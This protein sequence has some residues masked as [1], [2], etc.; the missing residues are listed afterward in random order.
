MQT[1]PPVISAPVAQAFL[2][3]PYAQMSRFQLAGVLDP[4]ADAQV[5]SSMLPFY[6]VAWDQQED[7]SGIAECLFSVGG[8]PG[9]GDYLPPVAVNTSHVNYSIAELGLRSGGIY[10]STVRCFNRAGLSSLNFS[11][12]VAVDALGPFI[13][14]VMDGSYSETTIDV[15]FV[16]DDLH[17]YA[18]WPYAVDVHTGLKECWAALGTG[19]STDAQRASIMGWR[20]TGTDLFIDL[21]QP[22]DQLLPTNVKLFWSVGC[23]D[24]VGNWANAS[25][26]GF[27]VDRTPPIVRPGFLAVLDGSWD[28]LL[29]NG[30]TDF[31]VPDVSYWT[32]R[33]EYLCRAPHVVDYE[34]GVPNMRFFLS[35]RANL[36][37]PFIAGP[38]ATGGGRLA[39]FTGL[40]LTQNTSVYCVVVAENGNGQTSSF[41][42]DGAFVDYTAPSC[43]VKAVS[44]ALDLPM[45]YT[46]TL[47]LRSLGFTGSWSAVPPLSV[48]ALTDGLGVM[49]RC[50]DAESGWGALSLTLGYA[51]GEAQLR[52][53]FDVVA[54]TLRGADG[55]APT[56][57]F[58]LD[59][60][61]L[62]ATGYE[63][64]R[65]LYWTARAR[66]RAGV[67]SVFST[68]AVVLDGTA[69][70][71]APWWATPAAVI[72]GPDF[73]GR[74]IT[75]SANLTHVNVSTYFVDQESDIGVV[76]VGLS[77]VPG[78]LVPGDLPWNGS[79]TSV[80]APISLL[81][82]ANVSWVNA[83]T[84]GE[85]ATVTI[86]LPQA[87]VRA[88]NASDVWTVW[89]T[90]R[91]VNTVGQESRF[92]SAG[93]LLDATPPVC[94]PM[95]ALGAPL[96]L[97]GLGDAATSVLDPR[98]GDATHQSFGGVL[99]ARYNCSDDGSGMDRYELSAELWT[100]S[101]WLPVC[102]PAGVGLET[103]GATSRC[104]VE[105][106]GRYRVRVDAYNRVGLRTVLLT[107][108]V[109]VDTT[110][111]SVGLL[112]LHPVPNGGT[113]RVHT[114]AAFVVFNL[115]F[116]SEP[117]SAL[118]SVHVAVGRMGEASVL[119]WVD[120]T[121]NV[122]R[123]HT[124][125]NTS[126]I[127]PNLGLQL[128][129]R[130]EVMVQVRNVLGL[131]RLATTATFIVDWTPATVGT[132]SLSTVALPPSYWRL[133]SFGEAEAGW[134]PG[135][136]VT[137]DLRGWRDEESGLS[138]FTVNLFSVPPARWASLGLQAITNPDAVSAFASQGRSVQAN[139]LTDADPLRVAAT[140]T[141]APGMTSVTFQGVTLVQ[142]MILVPWVTIRNGIN[143][144]TSVGG[145]NSTISMGVL[146]PG[147]VFDGFT[148]LADAAALPV[149]NGVWT[150]WQPFQDSSGARVSYTVG[151]GTARGSADLTGWVRA[152]GADNFASV[153]DRVV[154]RDGTT[155]FATVWGNSSTGMS[156]NSS[157]DGVLYDSSAPSLSFA[158]LGPRVG[159]HAVW[160][161]S[162][163]P[164]SVNWLC[165]DP[166]SNVSAVEV[167]LGSGPFAPASLVP[168]T[169]VPGTALAAGVFEFPLVALTNFSTLV[170]Q[171]TCTNSAGL[172]S[173]HLT[174][175]S[176]TDVT[177]PRARNVSSTA[178]VLSSVWPTRASAI[179][180]P[181]QFVSLP[182]RLFV[183]WDILDAES[184][185]G[186]A[187][188]CVGSS[189]NASDVV[190]CTPVGTTKG[191]VLLL[192]ASAAEGYNCSAALEGPAREGGLRNF[193]CL[194]LPAVAPLRH[195]M[196]LY[197][198][199]SVAN[200]V[201]LTT[202]V[203]ARAVVDAVAPRINATAA[204]LGYAW[205]SAASGMAASSLLADD[206]VAFLARPTMLEVVMGPPLPTS[207]A[208]LDAYTFTVLHAANRSVF[209][210]PVT[211]PVKALEPVASA[212]LPGASLAVLTTPAGAVFA[213]GSAY[214]VRIS[215]TTVGGL[216]SA[217]A[218]ALAYT[219]DAVPPV[220]AAA[221]I[222]TSPAVLDAANASAAMSAWPRT[223]SLT[224]F[225]A[226]SDD[227][228]IAASEV[229]VCD[230]D[231][232][233]GACVT[234]WLRVNG[235]NSRGSGN[236]TANAT[237]GGV[238]LLPGRRFFVRVRLTDA[239]GQ[240]AGRATESVIVENRAP[241]PGRM[242]A[243]AGFV[244]HPADL[245]VA[246]TP[247]SSPTT[248]VDRYDVCIVRSTDKELR[249]PLLPC[250]RVPP[251]AI[252]RTTRTLRGEELPTLDIDL[253]AA[254]PASNAS[255]LAALLSTNRNVTIVVRGT[256]GAGLSSL[257]YS[258]PVIYDPTGPGIA[259]TYAADPVAYALEFATMTG[260]NVTLQPG[261]VSW[262]RP[263][264]PL[265]DSRAVKNAT[266]AKLAQLGS[267][268]LTGIGIAWAG[269]V[270]PESGI[271]PTALLTVMRCVNGTWNCSVVADEEA[272]RFATGFYL[273]Q[274][275]AV[276]PN[277]TFRANLTVT[278]GAGETAS[279]VTSIPLTIDLEPPLVSRVSD[280][281][282]LGVELPRGFPGRAAS[283]LTD[284]V[285]YWASETTAAGSWEATDASGIANYMWAVCRAD[286]TAP[287][288]VASDAGCPVPWS[289]ADA[290]TW[291]A[292]PLGATRLAPGG[293][294]RTWVRATDTAGN[295]AV[296]SSSGYVVDVTGPVVD[297]FR[298]DLP[299][300]VGS[301]RILKPAVWGVV[302]AE[303]GIAEVQICLTI[304]AA[305]NRT[306]RVLLPCTA[307]PLVQSA[308]LPFERY[309][310][311]TTAAE[312]DAA[313]QEELDARA[314]AG[315]M[316]TL[317]S[318]DIVVRNRAALASRVTIGAV[319]VD[320]A[321]VT[322]RWLFTVE[323][324]S[325]ERVGFNAS[326]IAP[327][328]SA[329]RDLPNA[330]SNTTELG[331]AW[332]LQAPPSGVTSLSVGLGTECGVANVVLPAALPPGAT[333][334]SFRAQDL[335]PRVRY[336]LTLNTTTGA[337]VLSTLCSTPLLVD[338]DPP[339]AGVVVDGFPNAT[340]DVGTAANSTFAASTLVHAHGVF[341]A[342]WSGFSD[343]DTRVVS[344]AA[345]VCEASGVACLN[346]W[347]TVS[348][349]TQVAFANLA[350]EDGITYRVH[351]RG[352]DSAG[353]ACEARS[354]GQ[355]YD[356]SVPVPPRR[357]VLPKPVVS[358]WGELALD[359]EEFVDAESGIDRYE[360]ELAVRNR[361][362]TFHS[363]LTPTPIG[364]NTAYMLSGA[365]LDAVDL[366]W[367]GA[368]LDDG[369]RPVRYRAT[370][371]AVNRAG[372]RSHRQVFGK[373]DDTPP[374]GGE[375]VFQSVDG[376]PGA[377]RLI[378]SVANASTGRVEALIADVDLGDP[379]RYQVS[380]HRLAIAFRGF[381]D[382]E[383][384]TFRASDQIVYTYAVG[385][386]PGGDEIV[387]RARFFVP[388]YHV[389]D[390]ASL[391]GVERLP[392]TDAHMVHTIRLTGLD[393]PNGA[394]VYA[395][396]AA[397]NAAGAATQVV[398]APMTIDATTPQS[399]HLQPLIDLQARVTETWNA[400]AFQPFNASAAPGS[401]N[402]S[403]EHDSFGGYNGVGSDAYA[404][405]SADISRWTDADWSGASGALSFAWRGWH[406]PQSALDHVEYSVVELGEPAGYG[407]E[408]RATS[409]ASLLSG[410]ARVLNLAGSYAAYLAAHSGNTARRL[411][412]S[413]V[414]ARQLLQ[415]QQTASTDSVAAVPVDAAAYGLTPFNR[416]IEGPLDGN[417]DIAD[418]RTVPGAEL[419]AALAD[420]RAD[421]PLQ[422]AFR[423][424]LASPFEFW[425]GKPVTP[426]VNAGA[427]G[428]GN[429]TVTA[430]L[431]AGKV[432]GIALRA[433]SASS[434][435]TQV[436]SDGIRVDT[437][438]GAPCFG[439]IK[440][441]IASARDDDP[442]HLAV[443]SSAV[444]HAPRPSWNVTVDPNDPLGTRPVSDPSAERAY[445][446]YTD[447]VLL[448][449]LQYGD[450][451]VQR[452]T[453]LQRLYVCPEVDGYAPSDLNSL[454]VG[455]GDEPDP[456]PTQERCQLSLAPLLR[457]SLRL[458][459]LADGPAEGNSTAS[460]SSANTVPAARVP[461]NA[462]AGVPL[463]VASPDLLPGSDACCRGGQDRHEPAST[464][465]DIEL[466][467]VRPV[468]GF[469][470]TLA[471]VA[472]PGRGSSDANA[473][474]Y[475]VVGSDEGT[476]SVVALHHRTGAFRLLDF[477][478]AT[479]S[480][481][482]P[483]TVAASRV[484]SGPLPVPSALGVVTDTRVPSFAVSNDEELGVYEVH[485]DTA[486]A[487]R[488][489]AICTPPECAQD[490]GYAFEDMQ[491]LTRSEQ[492]YTVATLERDPSVFA[493]G[494]MG[495][496][497][498]LHNRTLAVG[499]AAADALRAA[500]GADAP[501]QRLAGAVQVC[502]DAVN[503]LARFARRTAPPSGAAA[504]LWLAPVCAVLTPPTAPLHGGSGV[505]EQV[506]P[507]LSRVDQ[508][509]FGTSLALGDG[510]LAV[511]APAS[512]PHYTSSDG[513]VLMDAV[514][515]HSVSRGAGTG[516][517]VPLAEGDAFSLQTSALLG[518]LLRNGTATNRNGTSAAPHRPYVLLDP[519]VIDAAAVPRALTFAHSG[520]GS[521][522]DV[523]PDGAALVVGAPA[524]ADGRGRVYAYTLDAISGE[525]RLACYFDGGLAGFSR[526]GESVQALPV[527]AP[528]AAGAAAAA[529]D[530]T[531][532]LAVASLHGLSLAAN[533]SAGEVAASV[534]VAVRPRAAAASA[535]YQ[536]LL[537]SSPRSSRVLEEM[538]VPL[539]P[540]VAVIGAN[541][542]LD[543]RVQLGLAPYDAAAEAAAAAAATMD[544]GAATGP[545]HT[546][547][548]DVVAAYLASVTDGGKRVA[549]A[550]VAPVV[551]AAGSHLL[552]ADALSPTWD[553][554]RFQPDELSLA[555]AVRNASLDEVLSP[556]DGQTSPPEAGALGTGR[557][558]HTAFCPRDAVRR[559]SEPQAAV[560][561]YV[562]RAC[563][564]QAGEAS[565][566]SYGGLSSICASCP[567]SG[568][569]VCTAGLDASG[570]PTSTVF[571]LN[572]TGLSLSQGAM[573]K[574][575]VRATTASG[576][577]FERA[578]PLLQVDATPPTPPSSGLLDGYYSSDAG[579]D[580]CNQDL[581]YRASLTTA[582]VW[583]AGFGEDASG[584]DRYKYGLSRVPCDG[585]LRRDCSTRTV[586]VSALDGVIKNFTDCSPLEV[587][588]RKAWAVR[589]GL[590]DWELVG[591]AAH[592]LPFDV[593]APGAF[594]VVPLYDAGLNT[595]HRWTRVVIPHA[596]LAF[597]CAI[598]YNRAGLRTIIA[599]NGLVY[600]ATPGNLTRGSV[601]DGLTGV[602][603]DQQATND[604]LTAAWVSYD[605]ES[606]IQYSVLAYTHDPSPVLDAY[607][608]IDAGAGARVSWDAVQVAVN[609][610]GVHWVMVPAGTQQPDMGKAAGLALERGR[611]YYA[612][613]RSLNGAGLWSAVEVSDGVTV[614]RNEIKP[615]P[616]KPATVGFDAISA[617]ANYASPEAQRT[618][619]QGTV[620]SLTLPAGALGGAAA[621]LL[622]GAVA[623]DDLAGPN[624]TA[625]DLPGL[626]DPASTAPPKRNLLFGDYS[627]A[628]KAKDD[629][630][631]IIE[632]YRF[633][634]PMTVSLFYD[635]PAGLPAGSRYTPQLNLFIVETGTWEP[636]YLSCPPEDR[637]EVLDP[638]HR[639]YTVN[640]CHLTQFGV[641]YQQPPVGL[642]RPPAGI[643]GLLT[644]N[645]GSDSSSSGSIGYGNASS[646]AAVSSATSSASLPTLLWHLYAD[647]PPLVLD[648][649][650]SY[651]PDGQ[652]ASLVWRVADAPALAALRA[653]LAAG[654]VTPAEFVSEAAAI[655]RKSLTVSGIGGATVAVSPSSLTVEAS[656][657]WVVALDVTD[658]DGA[659][660][661]TN[662]SILFNVPPT[663]A[664]SRAYYTP[665]SLV[666]AFGKADAALGT[667]IDPALLALAARAGPDDVVVDA[668][669]S[670]DPDTAIVGWRWA[671]D[672][673]ASRWNA[674][675]GPAVINATAG[676][677]ALVRNA[678]SGVWTL[679]LTATDA[680]GATT[681]GYVMAGEGLNTLITNGSYISVATDSFVLD[682]SDTVS[683]F[684]TSRLAFAWSARVRSPGSNFTTWVSLPAAAGPAITVTNVTAL[685]EHVF[686]V[687]A[688]DPFG[689]SDTATITVNRNRAPV[690]SL[691]AALPPASNQSAWLWCGPPFQV[692]LNASA[693]Y[694]PDGTPLSVR[695]AAE[696]TAGNVTARFANDEF[697]PIGG[698]VPIFMPWGGRT[699]SSSVS[700]GG[701]VVAVRNKLSMGSY[702]I[703]AEVMDADGAVA[704]SASITLSVGADGWVAVGEPIPE[705][706]ERPEYA[707]TM[708]PTPST[709]ASTTGSNT[710]TPSWTPSSTRTRSGTKTSSAT[711]SRTAS[712]TPSPSQTP[713][714]T[715]T[716]SQTSS[717]T[718]TSS[719]TGTSTAT[720]SV[721]GTASFTGS[722][723]ASASET[724]SP[725]ATLTPSQT[726]SQ[727]PTSTLSP[728]TP[729]RTPT[730]SHTLLPPA[731]PLSAGSLLVVRVGPLVD[732][733]AAL[734]PA[735]IDELAPAVAPG[736]GPTYLQTLALPPESCRLPALADVTAGHG[737]LTPSFAV[738]ADSRAPSAWAL[739]CVHPAT[740]ELMTA[741][742]LPSGS[743]TVAP[744]CGLAAAAAAAAGPCNATFTLDASTGH[745]AGVAAGPVVPGGV[746]ETAPR[747][748]ASSAVALA[749]LPGAAAGLLFS[750]ASGVWA[751]AAG[752]PLSAAAR[753]LPAFFNSSSTLASALLHVDRASGDVFVVGRPPRGWVPDGHVCAAGGSAVYR[754]ARDATGVFECSGRWA[755]LGAA[756]FRHGRALS[757]A[758][759]ASPTGGYALL[760]TSDTAL[761]RC[762]LPA[763]P[764]GREIV[765]AEVASVVDRW[766]TRYAYRGVA[767][768]T[769]TA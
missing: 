157:S 225:W 207:L 135:A 421:I 337:G 469:G 371:H 430:M 441:G 390:E 32:S 95:G 101:G 686:R 132:V 316:P 690:A 566:A 743:L 545:T 697:A 254:L 178:V 87:L 378:A 641:Y 431:E 29:A 3:V 644:A 750:N 31:N 9:G 358:A 505:P 244:A 327:P 217:D 727:S 509:G 630:G 361:N 571:Q 603:Y 219:P 43:E 355:I 100:G 313:L 468:Y 626:V 680:L 156:V 723:T 318:V 576:R 439:L 616:E 614:G 136:N 350:P 627:F 193:T 679:S 624:G 289:P 685:G 78:P 639:M 424:R 68:A 336:V 708:R 572:D 339:L 510:V 305:G 114:A 442:A 535:P 480:F 189:A 538:G 711:A 398:S 695:W 328:L 565:Q 446:P 164:V 599:S 102:A 428:S 308:A 429:I 508:T 523:A 61:A 259:P 445:S 694:D 652:V 404:Y 569:A 246:F 411:L 79:T 536:R 213:P 570:R 412:S 228:G 111:P 175:M 677:F 506:V 754:F 658:S 197:A 10:W 435:F 667:E 304:G 126:A 118:E 138:S 683:G 63:P 531:L 648:A 152:K 326:T 306:S 110:P 275:V 604:G 220:I 334:A 591:T 548:A 763:A 745:L 546:P 547:L 479:G 298:A 185:T 24:N 488:N 273:L 239:A 76:Q 14:T 224:V 50:T 357:L 36:N 11:S 167:S 472:L 56:T 486:A 433:Y 287:T 533:G 71:P 600:D 245:V 4:N 174:A 460:N 292:R 362:G 271:A 94:A 660:T 235:T 553:T 272:V 730:A 96:V 517:T 212:V 241:L 416:S 425:G 377:G 584:I 493:P 637:F 268:D 140:E 86:A 724:G 227:A 388:D 270:D 364:I 66:N 605:Y 733:S 83:T 491:L 237:I 218:I 769:D 233:T 30:T 563:T 90:A 182:H 19:T 60:R 681:T 128:G 77:A 657:K 134:V 226:A 129:R 186:P 88:I 344:Y 161:N 380:R 107:D 256:T 456:L 459:L 438:R 85:Y 742:L 740:G 662:V 705:T 692:L 290:N 741:T 332:Q 203:T 243:P 466:R 414:R 34:S 370:L 422:P 276:L 549:P 299:A 284:D 706:A 261:G 715:P 151:W 669:P 262:A 376:L 528:T 693:S 521:A 127:T 474:A 682:A 451:Y 714:N 524:S 668:S 490:T 621:S 587:D 717:M 596:T 396:V 266:L 542:T 39:Y 700:A 190:P 46:Q 518:A 449:V 160:L 340:S 264:T 247:F 204:R 97:D 592:P 450:P 23:V 496:S 366:R 231:D 169:R 199:V 654:V 612:A 689:R 49:V 671:L 394:T 166:H 59:S 632:G 419:R 537:A 81:V 492:V 611:V 726:P 691:T 615:D 532:A 35:T 598:A 655:T 420:T 278:S 673:N 751:M 718:A 99:Y 520:F 712:G 483:V 57:F 347:I 342:W 589:M 516:A 661:T 234:P 608:D 588:Y 379:P 432:Y 728:V 274:G 628:I 205:R 139:F 462:S 5:L 58:T 619:A 738:G 573:Y 208:P 373:L 282:P 484:L 408:M 6:G 527:G 453:A 20:S 556:T 701:A 130:Y 124:R 200:A 153:V 294:Y 760:A 192:G 238:N 713:S 663:V 91:A 562:C 659:T 519:A 746:D 329:L 747:T 392:G 348:R 365:A 464:H 221:A 522:L 363:L 17:A 504:Y 497:I 15:N 465:A 402:L 458:Q 322:A 758:A 180:S 319:R 481:F 761:L 215:A 146:T 335:Q 749:V 399:S 672:V 696:Y 601:L 417:P 386:T 607:L 722:V 288:T 766:S 583:H 323:G 360:L 495:R 594:D 374:V 447:R 375:V 248:R 554:L 555:A 242:L 188:L 646:T 710:A 557:V 471:V 317:L 665:Q 356:S 617:S 149:T 1:T 444:T 115:A 395:S 552:L 707:C 568:A 427:A 489:S 423:G 406:D 650:D 18:A 230:G 84:R 211:L 82:P 470:R 613:V 93:V 734:L 586:T 719:G 461:L 731:R 55:G 382:P 368:E 353:N 150:S 113:D 467:P 631:A 579:C 498:A 148:P 736:V 765:C 105:H 564:A 502:E 515:L 352:F 112:R 507:F 410:A 351:V 26:D 65:A 263:A 525:P 54:P 116:V 119:P 108:G 22:S 622:A 670:L 443:I 762:M 609:T 384:D 279:F 634:R 642:V 541:A 141:I 74:P 194:P 281:L 699:N 684:A 303:S 664:F 618:A 301:W 47:P 372:L 349:E 582:G 158:G 52:L 51:P 310:D 75:A 407:P 610:V 666:E 647:A 33:T 752:A 143:R 176:Y 103:R 89:A 345:R 277:A 636:A 286:V 311:N 21:Y 144:L 122:T 676:P 109:T 389:V 709:S 159:G 92:R 581:A 401:G 62:V 473:R 638:A 702:A 698:A 214:E 240:T 325:W 426:F 250:T 756:L 585:L 597:G 369:S 106:G 7:V 70:V 656:G 125:F 387:R 437:P 688:V 767:V 405:D 539:C 154:V 400:S 529:P 321:G 53:P 567:P 606:G 252:S 457:Y 283:Q 341:R 296:A 675:L 216:E 2:P 440:V 448:S 575:Y 514:V 280:G 526:L 69:P 409:N 202:V 544:G 173:T 574:V 12:P 643:I 625:A 104:P 145:G 434:Q 181:T 229:R 454:Y 330:T 649:S 645:S 307:V 418:S 210:P 560:V 179:V 580:A 593:D 494:G 8:Y 195:G 269:I 346:N 558:W 595:S 753:A 687:I 476:A 177:P 73:F 198:S 155:V 338:L 260:T 748:L 413:A 333:A 196:T 147:R 729:T 223:D 300:A 455:P 354:P 309:F 236:V 98:T 27:V 42:S 222:G 251:G 41:I 485:Y 653:D 25:S 500:A 165:T 501:L 80:S 482:A 172:R 331:F 38:L 499:G 255:S 764:G 703:T 67:T 513:A 452:P 755:R 170:A 477:A 559:K 232:P 530:G 640:I 725:S 343:F 551:A 512:T 320:T 285:S 64:G 403:S 209:I 206:S 267:N 540:L 258:E 721:T 590:A 171:V 768:V 678:A 620:G 381:S 117:E 28:A 44:G 184:H 291:V 162:G 40:N 168:A 629:S 257:A 720:R 121:R 739:A 487:G 757:G 550:A 187:T 324:G 623:E 249:A 543:V 131:S 436:L 602:D 295:V 534:V 137:L 415:A 45:A 674:T 737:A 123:A 633:A 183:A 359:W 302:D 48:G 511:G 397:I 383:A 577:F 651:D 13:G 759:A 393:I 385:T 463:H 735:F 163:L 265:A 475:A 314:A 315:G 201:G 191:A 578:G 704:M 744:R 391:R 635:V 142:G 297:G 561:P 312:A 293:T 478:S 716:A 732:P 72:P 120:I 503:P 16:F 367:F 253:A 37:G 133:A